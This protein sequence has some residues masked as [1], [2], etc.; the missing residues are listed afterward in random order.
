MGDRIE[1]M[2]ENQRKREE[3]MKEKERK[4]R[5]EEE[6]LKKAKLAAAPVTNK[7]SIGASPA[8]NEKPVPQENC[9]KLKKNLYA[10]LPKTERGK[11]ILVGG[12]PSGENILY[13]VGSDVIVRSLKNPLVAEIYSEH[14]RTTTVARYSPNRR[15]IASAD[16]TGT[17]RIWNTEIIQG[18]QFKL[19]FEK[20]CFGGA[21]SDL[22]W[23]P[24][25]QRLVVV[26]NG[27]DTMGV[28][29]F[30]DG[31]ASAGTIS[32]H[33]KTI[34]SCDF[35]PRK[36]W[37]IITCS[38]DLGINW[39]EGPPFK[40][41][42]G[43]S[44]HTRY[45]NCVR[46]SPNG[47]LF[48]SVGQD[49][50]GLI[51]DGETGQKK[52]TLSAAAEHA[53][54]G[55]I[56]CASWSGD[57]KQALTASGDRTAKIWDISSGNCV[58]TFNFGEDV[59]D[60][61]ISCL[62]QGEFLIS[63]NLAGWLSYL[64]PRSGKVTQVIQG[65]QKSVQSL[66]YH[67]GSHSIYTGS[68][69]AVVT[70]WNAD[71]G[72]NAKVT[73]DGHK[74]SVI[75]M[76][77]QGDEV[78]TCSMDD[79]YRVTKAGQN[80]SGPATALGSR[81]LAMGV[82]KGTA[83]LAVTGTFN[84]QLQLLRAGKVVGTLAVSFNPQSVAVNYGGT[85]AAVGGDDNKIHIYNISGNGLTAG[86]VLESHRYP[87]TA[88]AFS[89]DGKHFASG[90]KN[91]VIAL[92]NA[93]NFSKVHDTK[94]VYHTSRVNKLEFSP[95]SNHLVSCALDTSV[96]AWSLQNPDTR[97]HIK[98]AHHGGVND[99]TWI[100]NN[101]VASVGVDASLRTWTINF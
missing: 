73:G 72:Q 58:Q 92:W 8:G 98:A 70:R 66:A 62:W 54:S 84:Q 97:V 16:E 30:I 2:L 88:V 69:D 28:V 76:G 80:Y 48:L 31:G 83:S 44:E 55:G 52:S 13:C 40:W 96:V 4:Q 51:G 74:N 65:H 22:A 36:P 18:I 7:P 86:Q 34:T 90:D 91:N 53:H 24:D 19:H 47:D 56:Y 93:S 6:A 60:Q 67:A 101:T 25:S 71:N 68:Y 1:K 89:N 43:L 27:R 32:G 49:K 77:T 75:A 3:A 12:D 41:S 50:L 79:T 78:H 9:I 94:F 10:P 87:V 33:A 5:E 39:F 100:D 57:S 14:P 38:E 95:D 45:P 35:R 23:D 17:V 64:D 42:H 63:V 82:S 61:Q 11:P 21:I 26:G 20:K 81:P 37:K 85:Q 15:F 29:F 46:F 99:V 59:E